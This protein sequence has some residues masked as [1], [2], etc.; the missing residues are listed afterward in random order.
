MARRFRAQLLWVRRYTGHVLLDLY[1]A[2]GGAGVGP[3]VS[4][5]GK[6]PPSPWSSWQ[7]TSFLRHWAHASELVDVEISAQ[8]PP[9]ALHLSCD[10]LNV[11]LGVEP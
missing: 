5:L 8:S 11:V 2:E 1:V 4:V 3:A 7:M 10:G 9:T 6:L